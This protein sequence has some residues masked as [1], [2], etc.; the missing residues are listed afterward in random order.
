ML[1]LPPLVSD[2]VFRERLAAFE[3]WLWGDG[4]LA[5]GWRHSPRPSVLARRVLALSDLY[6]T[7]RDAIQEESATGEHLMAKVLYF[8]VSDA[9]KPV[10]VLRELAERYPE[11]VM[12]KPDRPLR[13]CDAG[14][15]VGATSVG[16]LLALDSSRVAEAEIEALD[17]HDRSL[18]MWSATTRQAAVIAGIRL[19]AKPVACDLRQ[20]AQRT[21]PGHDLF[22]AQA[23]LNELFPTAGAT[24]EHD[25]A[26]MQARAD[27]VS[28]LTGGA[29]GVVIEPALKE[30][31]RPL[32]AVRDQLLKRGGWRVLAPCPHD[33]PCPMLRSPRDWCHEVR[34]F[35]PMKRVAEIQAQT[36]R[37]DNRTKFSFLAVAPAA[38]GLTPHA[39]D[40][41][42]SGRLVSDALNSKGKMERY[43]CSADGKI[44]QLRLLDRDRVDGNRVLAEAERG[45][46]VKIAGCE[47]PP[48][49][50]RDA[51]VTT[52]SPS[53]RG[54]G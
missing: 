2:D 33:Q 35:E 25:E 15:G 27:W 40:G 39:A 17:S 52:P 26:S 12:A 30:T 36:H 53:G 48:R 16:L 11:M 4:S 44:V 45:V 3:S 43:L 20:T 41:N 46:L 29:V 51:V 14:A 22:I 31:T 47:T 37:R 28:A 38:A 7:E 49:I 21:H 50:P 6:T 8:L 24:A 32:Q 13:V 10:M 5:L 34:L 1:T 19:N 23:L 54:R 42:L 9:P 18:D